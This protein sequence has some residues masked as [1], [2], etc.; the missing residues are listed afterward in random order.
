[1]AH[2]NQKKIRSCG[3]NY[4]SVDT[5]TDK[6]LS[7]SFVSFCNRKKLIIISNPPEIA[8]SHLVYHLV[9]FLHGK[10]AFVNVIAF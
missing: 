7:A 8:V 6:S 2:L 4:I 1:M 5:H 9:T 10:V 3:Q